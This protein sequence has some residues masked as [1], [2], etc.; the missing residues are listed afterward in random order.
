MGGDTLQALFQ[1]AADIA[2]IGQGFA[3]RAAAD[4]NANIFNTQARQAI[5]A[6]NYDE[7]TQRRQAAQVIAQQE[8][9]AAANGASDSSQIDVIR[10]NDVNLRADVLKRRFA[11]EVE[12][13]GYRSKAAMATFE[14]DQAL[15]AGLAGAGANL[16]KTQFEQRKD[17]RAKADAEDRL[18]RGLSIDLNGIY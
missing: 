4:Y 10:Q 8:V 15:Y 12:A 18:R 2:P 16:L 6:A 1:S 7:A 9:N 5:G 13:A 3:D 17:A 14:G 11:G